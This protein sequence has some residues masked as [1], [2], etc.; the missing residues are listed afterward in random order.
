TL[1]MLSQGWAGFSVGG[2]AVGPF[3]LLAAEVG[4][5]GVGMGFA[6]PASNNAALDLLPGR[7]AVITGIRGMFRSTGAV[8]GTA[9]IVLGVEISSDKAFGLRIIFALIAGV[10][11]ST[12]PLTFLIP[13]TARQRR[14]RRTG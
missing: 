6:A 14:R 3:W 5:A 12:L 1:L 11:L 4:L 2:L 9:L 7:A 10:L 13:D 8:M